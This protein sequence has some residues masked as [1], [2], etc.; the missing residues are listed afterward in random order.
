LW[1]ILGPVAIL[2]G[3]LMSLDKGPSR[4]PDADGAQSSP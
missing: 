4:V 3:L 1:L 2:F